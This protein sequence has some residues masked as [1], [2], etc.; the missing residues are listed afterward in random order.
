MTAHPRLDEWIRGGARL[1]RA[2][3]VPLRSSPDAARALSLVLTFDRGRLRL[4]PGDEPD[5]LAIFGEIEGESEVAGLLSAG[6]D[7]PWWALLGQALCAAAIDLDDAGRVTRLRMQFRE[8][9]ENPRFVRV[10]AS[11]GQL[12]VTPA[13]EL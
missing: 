8:D 4:E 6:D 7:E 3:R 13:T 12:R 5:T 9:G 2:E 10:A 11:D 1:L